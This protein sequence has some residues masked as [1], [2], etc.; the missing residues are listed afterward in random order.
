[1]S[2]DS[3]RAS[4]M[5]AAK[6]SLATLRAA[7]ERGSC[8]M[9]RLPAETFLAPLDHVVDAIALNDDARALV[10]EMFKATGGDPTVEVAP[11]VPDHVQRALPHG[12]PDGARARGGEPE[13]RRGTGMSRDG[14]ATRLHPRE[15]TATVADPRIHAGPFKVVARTD[16][17]SVVVDRRRPWNDRRVAGPCTEGEAAAM[18]GGARAARGVQ[19]RGRLEE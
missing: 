5:R 11:R 15:A 16:G 19:A 7:L 9:F 2:H 18:C 17:L 13:P 1:M 10:A 14:P 6:T 8:P 12:E 4:Y 3:D